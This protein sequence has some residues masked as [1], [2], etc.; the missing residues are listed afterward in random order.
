MVFFF[1]FYLSHIKF[2]IQ[3]LSVESNRIQLNLLKDIHTY[4]RV[5]PTKQ[6]LYSEMKPS[7]SCI[8]GNFCP[9]LRKKKDPILKC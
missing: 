8:E 1:L 3:R 4:A 7:Y 5:K 9:V 6:T 2:T